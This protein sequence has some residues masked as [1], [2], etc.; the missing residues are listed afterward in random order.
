VGSRRW[1]LSVGNSRA[2]E[3]AGITRDSRPRER[4]IGTIRGFR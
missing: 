2:L 4:P 3:I 1:A